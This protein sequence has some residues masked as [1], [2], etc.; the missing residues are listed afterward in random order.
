M[1]RKTTCDEYST[2]PQESSGLTKS[3]EIRV[4]TVLSEIGFTSCAVATKFAP[5]HKQGLLSPLGYFQ[6]SVPLSAC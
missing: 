4:D 2:I 5:H 1:R 3:L 6:V